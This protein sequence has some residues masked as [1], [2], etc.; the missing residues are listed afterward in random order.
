MCAFRWNIAVC[1]FLLIRNRL[2]LV[3]LGWRQAKHSSLHSSLYAHGNFFQLIQRD[4][5][6]YGLLYCDV[7]HATKIPRR[8]MWRRRHRKSRK[9]ICHII[10]TH[11]LLLSCNKK[12]RRYRLLYNC[13]LLSMLLVVRTCTIEWQSKKKKMWPLINLRRK[14]HRWMETG[15]NLMQVHYWC[16]VSISTGLT[17]S[18]SCFSSWDCPELYF[19]HMMQQ[20]LVASLLLERQTHTPFPSNHLACCFCAKTLHLKT[21]K[22]EERLNESF[23]SPF[24][25]FQQHS[26]TD[27]SKAASAADQAIPRRIMMS[28]RVWGNQLLWIEW[29]VLLRIKLG[30]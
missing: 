21:A 22:C 16:I 25:H 19:R 14:L 29:I 6:L 26:V 23:S 11:C 3:G 17:P 5:A 24:D 13:C 10:N 2:Q 30:V 9:K 7:I 1:S 15:F 8:K 20:L 12:R 18:T 4:F 27:K 28:K